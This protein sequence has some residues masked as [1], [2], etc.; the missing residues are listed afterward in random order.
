MSTQTSTTVSRR[1]NY[2][3]FVCFVTVD[4]SVSWLFLPAILRVFASRVF[5]AVKNP[6]P[7]YSIPLMTA[8][9]LS[10]DHGRWNFSL[11]LRKHSLRKYLSYRSHRSFPERWLWQACTNSFLL[12]GCYSLECWFWQAC[13]KSLW[14]I[15]TFHPSRYSVRYGFFSLLYRRTSRSDAAIIDKLDLGSS[16]AL[17]VIAPSSWTV[18]PLWISE[19]HSPYKVG[20]STAS[21]SASKVWLLQACWASSPLFGFCCSGTP[22]S[23]D[24]YHPV[25]PLTLA[26]WE[27]YRPFLFFDCGGKTHLLV[28]VSSGWPF[29]SRAR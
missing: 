18:D 17:K 4:S 1:S 3:G 19:S 11:A 16:S 2:W 22:F 26:S 8:V 10:A 5:W 23:S 24:L 6:A 13:L 12:P 14:I 20:R 27:Y 9:F 15:N 21:I 28:F 29:R 25:H 7:N